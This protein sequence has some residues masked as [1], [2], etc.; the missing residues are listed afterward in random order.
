[1][2]RADWAAIARIVQG[3]VQPAPV[4]PARAAAGPIAN[5]HK[6]DLA[7]AHKFSGKPRWLLPEPWWLQENWPA[8][9]KDNCLT[10]RSGWRH[11]MPRALV[12]RH[13]VGLPVE[14]GRIPRR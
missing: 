5:R 2:R 4:V 14:R 7:S 8:L 12:W 11:R 6:N 10:A 13:Q 1:M 9:H 3:T